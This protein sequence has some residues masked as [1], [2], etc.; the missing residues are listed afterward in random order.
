MIRKEETCANPKTMTEAIK[1]ICEHTVNKKYS[2]LHFTKLLADYIFKGTS[3]IE[4]RIASK[5]SLLKAN[6]VNDKF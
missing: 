6:M 3:R 1:N 5:I 4:E 2:R